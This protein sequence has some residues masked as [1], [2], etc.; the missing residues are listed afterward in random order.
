MIIVVCRVNRSGEDAGFGQS[1]LKDS[2]LVFDTPPYTTQG[3]PLLDL[4]SEWNR[5]LLPKVESKAPLIFKS[6]LLADLSH[7]SSSV[8]SNK[9]EKLSNAGSVAQSVK[10]CFSH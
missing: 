8:P 3:A 4:H 5:N 1:I 6:S 7:T 10:V 2:V 9:S